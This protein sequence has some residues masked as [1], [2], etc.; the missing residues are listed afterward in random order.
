MNK[1]KCIYCKKHGTNLNVEHAFID[2]LRQKNTPNWTIDNHVCVD[3]N[4]S[5][6]DKLDVVLS[7]CSP[8]AFIFDIIQK[9]RG[10]VTNNHK[11]PYQ[12]GKSGVNPI[13]VIFPNPV[14]DDLF[15]LHEPDT[16]NHQLNYLGVKALQPQMNLTLY[17]DGRTYKD[18]VEDNN[19]R[20]KT[21]RSQRENCITLDEQDGVI[22]IFNNTYVFPQKAAYYYIANIDAFKTKYM[23]DYPRTQY[24]LRTIYP[25]KDKGENIFHDFFNNIQAET[26]QMI[27]QDKNLPT[28]VFQN[29]IQVIMDR[30]AKKRFHRAIAKQ[31]FHCF[32]YHYPQ[33]T[34]HE[35]IFNGIKNFISRGSGSTH[36]F[37]MHTEIDKRILYGIYK[38]T[39]LPHFISYFIKNKNIVCQMDLFTGLTAPPFSYG[40]VLAGEL[41][42]SAHTS[43]SIELFPFYVH[44]SSLL[45]KNNEVKNIGE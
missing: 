16:V 4:S 29:H 24:H 31:A 1:G 27:P 34:G 9:E 22:R 15:I 2:S 3:C 6:G 20:Y 38:D 42:K 30:K 19:K 36:W 28:E 35:P 5:F 25:E 21:T 23:N 41:N 13:R 26:K 17:S 39:K 44:S 18:V 12:K 33:F 43:D 32:L 14:Y 7:K 37:V 8:I 10:I 40:V 45:K 11:S